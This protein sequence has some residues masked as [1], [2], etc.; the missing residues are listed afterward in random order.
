LHLYLNFLIQGVIMKRF[1][2]IAA[3]AFT[4]AFAGSAIAADGPPSSGQSAL[5]TALTGQGTAAP[6]FKGNAFVKGADLTPIS[7]P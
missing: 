6:A 1:F 3:V 2:G 4:V 7:L 5:A